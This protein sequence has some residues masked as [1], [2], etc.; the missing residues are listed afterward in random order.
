[1]IHKYHQSLNKQENDNNPLTHRK[2][3]HCGSSDGDDIKNDGDN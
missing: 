1:M 3:I 2:T